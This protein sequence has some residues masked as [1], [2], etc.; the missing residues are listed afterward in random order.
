VRPERIRTADPYELPTF[1]KVLREEMKAPEPSV[2]ITNRP[3]VLT[4][5]FEPCRPLKVVEEQCNGCSRCL[6]LVPGNYGD[7]PRAAATFGRQG[8]RSRLTTIEQLA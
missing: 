1:L 7:A 6:D 2:I 8:G 4:P 3:C 5:D